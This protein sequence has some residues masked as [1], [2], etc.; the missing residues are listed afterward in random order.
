[1]G[2]MQSSRA[3]SVELRRENELLLEQFDK[4]FR[5]FEKVEC[6]VGLMQHFLSGSLLMLN[7]LEEE[8]FPLTGA[9]VP[10]DRETEI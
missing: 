5:G 8:N 2:L 10:L 7:S 9:V 3:L 4:A 6:A 1:M